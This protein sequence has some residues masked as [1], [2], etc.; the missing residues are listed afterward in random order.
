MKKIFSTLLV[1]LMVVLMSAEVFASTKVEFEIKI[2]KNEKGGCNLYVKTKQ[3]GKWGKPKLV[4]KFRKKEEVT[5]KCKRP[6][7][8]SRKIKIKDNEY[9]F[10]SSLNKKF[11]I[12]KTKKTKSGWK[13]YGTYKTVDVT[14]KPIMKKLGIKY[15]ITKDY[16][17]LCVRN[18]L[19]YYGRNTGLVLFAI[20]N[21]K[22]VDDLDKSI[23]E[24]N[25]YEYETAKGYKFTIY[26]DLIE[27]EP[28]VYRATSK[29]LAIGNVNGKKIGAKITNEFYRP[30]ES[31]Y[32]YDNEEFR[33]EFHGLLDKIV[34]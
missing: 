6:C 17:R 2:P 4:K 21:C 12:R 24:L 11:C 30:Y 22:K 19:N 15:P 13:R 26:E 20:G 1:G 33:K 25:S 3:N 31:G 8:I 32:I 18:G 34:A 27:G 14:Y 29:L 16:H 9:S 7:K 28:K 10:V 5:Y 23:G